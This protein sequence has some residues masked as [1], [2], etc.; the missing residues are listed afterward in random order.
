MLQPSGEEAVLRR[1]IEGFLRGG[2][3]RGAVAELKM[4]FGQ[5]VLIRRLVGGQRDRFFRPGKGLTQLPLAAGS[6]PGGVVQVG[7]T[8]WKVVDDLPVNGESA[9]QDV[10]GDFRPATVAK[11]R[12]QLKNGI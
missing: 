9:V 10:V 1:K 5:R 7:C 11:A 3:S 12:N 6:H 2:D 4:H 8:A